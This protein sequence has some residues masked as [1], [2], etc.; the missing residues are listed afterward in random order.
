MTAGINAANSSLVLQS[1]GAI[2]QNTLN[3]AG[4][5]LVQTVD[6]AISGTTTVLLTNFS[7]P[8]SRANNYTGNTVIYGGGNQQTV[9]GVG[10]VCGTALDFSQATSPVSNIINNGISH[11]NISTGS[12]LVLVGGSLYAAGKVNTA[13]TQEFDGLTLSAGLGSVTANAGAGGSMT[14]ALN[15]I[16]RDAG[17]TALF[18]GSGTITT[19]TA[20]A[21]FAGGQP[22]I[23]GGW[24][25][26]GSVSSNANPGRKQLGR[27]RW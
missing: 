4:S 5:S 6:N 16:T 18:A 7:G 26:T 25:V 17:G 14:I 13:N 21:N 27:Q 11:A 9:A 19:T 22:T 15:A 1:V 3:M 10:G 23:L 8:L 24:A 20:N 2:S 12:T